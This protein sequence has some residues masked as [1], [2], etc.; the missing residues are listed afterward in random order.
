[1]NDRLRESVQIV[2]DQ[3]AS[4]EG[5]T[6]ELGI[7]LMGDVS[8][9]LAEAY[10]AIG[11]CAEEGKRGDVSKLNMADFIDP[12]VAEPFVSVQDKLEAMR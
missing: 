6:P 1:M 10:D 11:A 4:A 2:A 8:A 5:M 9:S 7:R 3:I 12:S